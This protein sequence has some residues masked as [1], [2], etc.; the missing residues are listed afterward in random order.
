MPRKKQR[1]EP[2]PGSESPPAKALKDYF[3]D[4][5]VMF[6]WKLQWWPAVVVEVAV[7][8]LF[9]RFAHTHEYR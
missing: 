4:E 1:K 2:Q 7:E 3:V 6:K 8:Q 9:V 5:V